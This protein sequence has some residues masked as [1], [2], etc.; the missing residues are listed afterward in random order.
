MSLSRKFT[1]ILLISIISIAIINVI[2]FYVFYDFYRKI[3]LVELIESKNKITIDYV[4]KL[5]EKQTIDDIDNIFSDIEIE[6][7]ELLENNK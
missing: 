7:F 5:I 2:A 3:Y 6:F 4:N 1:A